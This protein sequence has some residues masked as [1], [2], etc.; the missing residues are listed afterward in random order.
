MIEV[1]GDWQG[2][3]QAYRQTLAWQPTN[4]DAAV[5]LGNLLGRQGRIHEALPIL[6]GACRM[7]PDRAVVWGNLARVLSDLGRYA[8]AV[9][10]ARAATA[11]EPQRA[12]WWRVLGIA[13]RLQHDV[14]GAAIA[15]RKAIEL[16]PDDHAAR[17]ELGLA[18]REAGATEEARSVFA[19]TLAAQGYAERLRWGELLSLPAC[20][21]SAASARSSR[22][23]A[24]RTP[25]TASYSICGVH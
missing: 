19:Q 7:T 10:C 18:L 4:A 5:R 14:D 15:L 11:R 24:W 22:S 3:E 17:F 13:Q 23:T 20:S 2:A 1:K 9:Q 16:A 8:D 25:G 12:V 21:S 6:E